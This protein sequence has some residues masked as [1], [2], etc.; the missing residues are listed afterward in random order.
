MIAESMNEDAMRTG[1][2]AAIVYNDVARVRSILK[3]G[4]PA[5]GDVEGQR[6]RSVSDFIPIQN[7]AREGHNDII[8]VLIDYGANINVENYWTDTALHFAAQ[9]NNAETCKFLIENG[10]ETEHMTEDGE[11]ALHSAARSGRVDSIEA[12]V[13]MGAKIDQTNKDGETPLVVSIEANEYD[14]AKK[15]IELGADLEVET[16]SESTT[17]IRAISLQSSPREY[18]QRMV[19][20]LLKAGANVNYKNKRGIYRD[21][22]VEQPLEVAIFKKNHEIARKL[23]EHGANVMASFISTEEIF[24]FFGKQCHWIAKYMPPGEERNEIEK[25]THG[26]EMFGI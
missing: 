22:I 16:D 25:I 1:M 5:N 23:I 2:I 8:K 21:M 11:T 24:D 6:S 26:A 15:L 19:D 4:F 14:A 18:D 9:N 10:A 17:L 3:A 12:L 7:A 20:L 13:E